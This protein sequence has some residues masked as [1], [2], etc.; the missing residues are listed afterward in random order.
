M[1]LRV[2]E[3]TRCRAWVQTLNHLAAVSQDFEAQC[4]FGHM[5]GASSDGDPGDNA[6]KYIQLQVWACP[7]GMFLARQ[8]LSA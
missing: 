6:C 5:E 1:A 3:Y 7:F 2:V 4:W 8:R